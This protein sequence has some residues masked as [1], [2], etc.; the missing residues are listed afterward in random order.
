M[1]KQDVKETKVITTTTSDN[2]EESLSTRRRIESL[3]AVGVAF[4]V[5][6]ILII[7]SGQASELLRFFSGFLSENFGNITNITAFLSRLSYLVPLGL[8]LAVSFRLGIFNIGA[9][10]QSLGGGVAA[11]VVANQLNIGGFG[12]IFTLATGVIVGMMVALL[13]AFLKNEFK[14]NEVITSIMLNWIIFYIAKHISIEAS[15]LNTES[16]LRMEWIYSLFEIIG[17]RSSNSMNIGVFFIIPLVVLLWYAYSKTKWGFKQE[18]VGNNP[19]AGKFLG[20]NA[21]KEIYKA[22]AISGALAGLAGTIYMTGYNSSLLQAGETDIPAWTFDG[23][24]IALLGF[25][26]PIG[27]LGSAMIYS[28]FSEKIDL[29]IGDYGIVNIMV[30]IMIIMIA[31]SNYRITY[32][33]LE[34]KA[35]QK[36]VKSSKE[37]SNG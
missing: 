22:M 23:I 29:I 6:I 18:V 15:P 28:M 9:S 2:K 4:V 37:V 5:G 14:I 1:A 26:S 33:K 32:G 21:K 7:I 11:Y 12:F 19:K 13:I 20:I 17:G 27:V 35:K 31:R 10:G 8:A 3:K 30:A 36:K 34:K 25:N 24:T 16:D